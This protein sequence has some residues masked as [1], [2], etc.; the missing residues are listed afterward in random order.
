[1]AIHQTPLVSEAGPDDLAVTPPLSVRFF[2]EADAPAWDEFVR[3]HEHGSP[4]H[5]TAWKR[6]IEATFGYKPRYILAVEDGRIRG[7]LPLFLVQNLLVRRALISSPFAVYGGVLADSAEAREA[8]R[9]F[10][11]ELAR[12]LGVEYVELRNAW[13]EQCLGFNRVSR[14]VTFTQTIGP[15]QEAI[16]ESIARKTRRMVRKSLEQN[17]TVRREVAWSQPF[18]DLYLANLQ[19]LG[20]PAFPRKHFARLLEEF[21]GMVDV[22]EMLLDGKVVAAVMSFYFRDQV[23]PYYG[24]SDPA[25]NAAAPNNFMYYELMRWSGENGY[26]V[27]DFGRSKKESGGSYDFKSHWGMVERE[28]PYEILLV[29]RKE[30]PHYSPNNPRFRLFIGMW[31]RLPPW[32]TRLAGPFLIRLFP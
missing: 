24:A 25:A 8:I 4:F 13:P 22:R 7:V 20:T 6:S 30:L 2:E 19:R 11:E 23:L 14:Y 9:R 1:L 26:R 3:R 28:L 18:V 29:R 27:F 15:N 17:F 12:R 31:R 21:R 32:L 16:L 10:V 5:L